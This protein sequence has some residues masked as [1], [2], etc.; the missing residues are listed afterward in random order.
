MIKIFTYSFLAVLMFTACD[1]NSGAEVD[2]LKK[3]IEAMEAQLKDDV[4]IDTTLA[5]NITAAYIKYVDL[6]PEDS[7]APEYLSRSADIMKELPKKRLK[8]INVY[9][10]IYTEYPDHEL[11]GRSVFMIGFVFDEKYKD[12]KRAIKS[13]DFFLENYPNH[14]LAGEAKNLRA[15]LN[16]EDEVLD[17]VKNWMKQADSTQINSQ[18]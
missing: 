15:L 8:S 16:S 9:N 5:N 3:E 18:Q 11:A 4:S 10:R 13:Y 2:P 17:Q 7:L 12:S 14:E 6:H 1:Q